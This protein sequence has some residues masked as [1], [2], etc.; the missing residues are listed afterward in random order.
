MV[1]AVTQACGVSV[2]QSACLTIGPVC[3]V[4][5]PARRISPELEFGVKAQGSEEVGGSS[6]IC[7][8]KGAFSL[9]QS[10]F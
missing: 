10:G 7:A 1:L 6:H 2:L 5:G 3:C 8:G 9:G 4:D